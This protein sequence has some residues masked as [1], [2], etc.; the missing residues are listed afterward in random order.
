MIC[1]RCHKENAHLH[2]V[3]PI[4]LSCERLIL[5]EW[6]LKLS[7]DDEVYCSPNRSNTY[8]SNLPLA[9]TG[10]PVLRTVC[11][12]VLLGVEDKFVGRPIVATDRPSRQLL[13]AL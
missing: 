9:A 6:H 7:G 5:L 1:A 8:M 12:P 11:R 3:V 10:Q 4:C 2:P 13:A